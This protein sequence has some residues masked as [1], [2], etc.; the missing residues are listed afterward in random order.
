MSA[1]WRDSSGADAPYDDLRI[2]VVLGPRVESSPQPFTADASAYRVDTAQRAVETAHLLTYF[3]TLAEAGTSTVAVGTR[4]GVA[5]DEF[6][7]RLI[8][9][10]LAARD[11]R[12]PPDDQANLLTS[13]LVLRAHELGEGSLRERLLQVTSKVKRLRTDVAT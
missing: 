9:A 13:A 8:A 12:E 1:A 4:R 3:A 11:E 10:Y 7:D 6:S 2:D 5:I